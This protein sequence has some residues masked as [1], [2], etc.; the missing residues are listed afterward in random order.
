MGPGA[1]AAVGVV[2]ELVH[3]HAALRVGVV[4]RDVPADGCVGGFGGLLE[5][6]GAFD[7]GVTPED[8]DCGVGGLLA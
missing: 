7:L 3:V 8:G 2:A 4:A 1:G 6:D 5:G